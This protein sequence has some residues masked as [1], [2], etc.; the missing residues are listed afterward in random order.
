[1]P[2]IKATL[3]GALTDM[4]SKF[5][6]MGITNAKGLA[7]AIADYWSMGLSNLGGSVNAAPAKPILIAGLSEVNNGFKKNSEAA[8]KMADAIDSGFLAIIITG[9][10]H[11]IGGMSS[12]QKAVLK[13]GLQDAFS[14]FNKFT[15][16][17]QKLAG[18]ID[19]YTK[20]GQVYGTGVGPDFIPPM[21]PLQ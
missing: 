17:A 19:D 10:K 18:A 14:E 15:D 21:G 11:G 13:S 3:Q 16:H 5:N 12:A 7:N 20:T 1:M 9:G 2:L 4:Y 8:N 6:K